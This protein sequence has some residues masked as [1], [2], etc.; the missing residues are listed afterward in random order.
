MD[1]YIVVMNGI[2]LAMPWQVNPNDL[3]SVMKFVNTLKRDYAESDCSLC[4]YKI[5]RELIYYT[6]NR[7]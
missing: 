4:V 1:R 7:V 5:S 3:E 6:K 2:A